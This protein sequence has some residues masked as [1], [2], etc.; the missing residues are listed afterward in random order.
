MKF[1]TSLILFALMIQVNATILVHNSV[2][3]RYTP[4]VYAVAKE[5]GIQSTEIFIAYT[6]LKVDGMVRPNGFGGFVILLNPNSPVNDLEIIAHE[7]VHIKQHQQGRWNLDS[8]T[9]V[10]TAYGHRYVSPLAKEMEVEAMR[11]GRRLGRKFRNSHKIP[12]Q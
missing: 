2:N 10:F 3:Y 1:L 8:P 5:L 12:Q 7:L 9:T 4:F 11:E 6:H